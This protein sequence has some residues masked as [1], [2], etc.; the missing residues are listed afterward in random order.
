MPAY[1]PSKQ[2]IVISAGW[3]ATDLGTDLSM[4]GYQIPVAAGM[5]A[6]FCA[7]ALWHLRPSTS[8][9]PSQ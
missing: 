2:W 9:A 4:G 1:Q 7:A 3:S 8:P 5:N 6:I